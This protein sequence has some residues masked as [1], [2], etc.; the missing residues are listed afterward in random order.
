MVA[1]YT[2]KRKTARWPM[3]L[4]FNMLDVSALNSYVLWSDMRPEWHSGKSFRRRL[5]LEELGKALVAPLMESRQPISH[6]PASVLNTARRSLDEASASHTEA[7]PK[8][9]MRCFLCSRE[10]DRK[11]TLKCRTCTNPICKSH[12]VYHAYCLECTEETSDHSS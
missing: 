11:T 6:T 7:T 9:R 1:A 2:C 4:F 8:K 3:L 10:K 5:F 12:A